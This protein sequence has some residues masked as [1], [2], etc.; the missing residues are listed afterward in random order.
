MENLSGSTVAIARSGRTEADAG[1]TQVV[2]AQRA[3]H[4]IRQAMGS[5]H[6]MGLQMATATEEQT[7][8]VEEVARQIGTIAQSAENN[9]ALAVESAQAG[10]E[11]AGTARAMHALVERFN[12]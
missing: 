3:L 7:R 6:D 11:L 4:D 1:L 8:V 10:H 5:L 2:A 9:A 12:R